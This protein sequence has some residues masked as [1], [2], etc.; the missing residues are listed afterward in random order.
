MLGRLNA[1]VEHLPHAGETCVVLGWPLG[2]DGRKR[3]AGTALF[4]EDERVLGSACATWIAP[5]EA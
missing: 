4:G 1:K 2:E 3:Y 5:R